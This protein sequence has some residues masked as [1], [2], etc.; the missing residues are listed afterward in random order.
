MGKK[1]WKLHNKWRQNFNFLVAHGQDSIFKMRHL[2]AI[3]ILKIGLVNVN[4]L[5][6]FKGNG[7]LRRKKRD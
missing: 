1:S 4:Y 6:D 3:F 2:Y 7:V 5:D